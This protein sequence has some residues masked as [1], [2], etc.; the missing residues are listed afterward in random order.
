MNLVCCVRRSGV[1]NQFHL[2]KDTITSLS[3]WV[4]R[5]SKP[6]HLSGRE[7]KGL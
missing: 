3:T 4:Q 1:Y 6:G 7:H 5:E 2:I